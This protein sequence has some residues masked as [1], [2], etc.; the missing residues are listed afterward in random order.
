MFPVKPIAAMLRLKLSFTTAVLTFA[1]SLCASSAL[2]QPAG[3]TRYDVTNYRLEA[4]L[5][6]EYHTLRAG[7][8]YPLVPQDATRSSVFELNGSLKVESVEKDGKV[9]TGFV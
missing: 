8:T 7:A 2:A 9:L 1:F 6:P 4:Q 3:G 5:N